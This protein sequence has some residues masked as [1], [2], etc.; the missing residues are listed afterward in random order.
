MTVAARVASGDDVDLQDVLAAIEAELDAAKI[1]GLELAVVR[2]GA[3]LFA[4]GLGVRGVDDPSPV[5]SATLFHHGSCGKAYTGLLAAL[6]A[7]DGVVDLDAP[8]RRY[9]PELRLPDPVIADRV[10]LRDVLCHRSGLGRHD[11]A[12]IF[13]PTWSPEQ[14]VTRLE[15]LPLVGDLRAQWSYSNFGFALAGLAL[16]RA[17]GTSWETEIHRRV[18]EPLGMART[19]L[20][21]KGMAED[22]DHATPHLLRDGVAKPT[23]FRL[24]N[25]I[26]PAGEVASCAEDSVRWLRAQLCDGPLDSDAVKLAQTPFMLVPAGAAPFPELEFTGYGLG[27]IS[28]RY[29]DRPLI[30]HNGGVDGFSTQ[31]LLLPAD[32]I[33]IVASANLFPTNVSLAVV[34]DIADHLLGVAGDE[35]WCER[36]RAADSSSPEVPDQPAPASS[37]PSSPAHE[38]ADYAGEFVNG[39]YGRLEVLLDGD[40]LRARIGEFDLDARHRHFETWDLRYD[41]LDADLTLTFVTLSD[42]RVQEALVEV[43]SETVRFRR[44]EA[45][46]P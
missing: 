35:S 2:D 29:R 20:T 5:A 42:G 11:L 27:W 40:R 30:W 33:G 19:R 39:G 21:A 34:L 10:T 41:A 17:A 4:G 9:V 28:G 15:H 38:P 23:V 45:P 24:L 12:W 44:E 18:L 37:A 6:L 8:V 3:A 25:G 26:A 32:R 14:I 22:A 43:E 16:G 1:P 36:L 46:Q 7:A 31:T 13:N